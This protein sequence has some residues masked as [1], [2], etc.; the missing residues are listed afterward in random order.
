MSRPSV[1]DT[2]NYDK[3]LDMPTQTLEEL[4]KDCEKAIDDTRKDIVGNYEQAK[5]F[6]L[7]MRSLKTRLHQLVEKTEAYKVFLST[8]RDGSLVSRLDIN[9]LRKNF[10]ELNSESPLSISPRMA[11]PEIP[12]L[13]K[14]VKTPPMKFKPRTSKTPPMK[15]TIKASSTVLVRDKYGQLVPKKPNF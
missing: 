9:S 3:L 8:G 10:P 11:L 15:K 2:L 13:K 1:D 12:K 5:P 4:V 7:K 14:L 6:L